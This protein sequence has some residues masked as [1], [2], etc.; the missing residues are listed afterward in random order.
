MEAV[1]ARFNG[2]AYHPSLIVAELGGSVLSNQVEFLD[3]IDAGIVGRL[4]IFALVVD[5]AVEEKGISLFPIAIDIRP[6]R[7]DHVLWEL[8]RRRVDVCRARRE[9]SQL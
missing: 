5:L 8:H 4:V 3:R 2:G 9:Q 1:G 7:V 6:A